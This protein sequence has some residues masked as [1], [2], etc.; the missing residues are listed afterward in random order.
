[1]IYIFIF[2]LSIFLGFI[3]LDY[4]NKC[5]V[6]VGLVYNRI[7]SLPTLKKKMLKHLYLFIAFIPFLFLLILRYNVG[8]DYQQYIYNYYTYGLNSESKEYL[9][10]FVILIANYFN[11][12]LLIPTIIGILTYCFI[13]KFIDNFSTNIGYSIL[14]IFVT[15]FFFMSCTMMR[16]CLAIAIFL[17]S[18]KYL[19]RNKYIHFIILIILA[20]LFH[21][22]SIIYLVFMLIYI[23]IKN[24]NFSRRIRFITMITLLIIVYFMSSFLRTLL[25]SFLNQLGRYEGYFGSEHDSGNFSGS[26]F[27]MG[28]APFIPCLLNFKETK[29]NKLFCLLGFFSALI[30]ILMPVIPNGER[31][32]FMFSTCAVVSNCFLVNESKYSNN[33]KIV[34][35]SFVTLISLI[36]MIAYFYLG[37]SL[38]VFPYQSIFDYL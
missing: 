20:T 24:I 7:F 18:T 16:Q 8:T 14:M 9:F 4:K 26:H 35:L 2:S 30:T 11:N 27:F 23:I 19:L 31:L 28:I 6:K 15:G 10:E 25:F 22:S 37:K 32:I 29:I 1:M 33:K 3:L 34:I 21:T 13:A 5:L 36:G 17:Y 38:N 12:P